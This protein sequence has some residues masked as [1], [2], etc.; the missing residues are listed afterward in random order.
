MAGLGGG[1]GLGAFII[2]SWLFLVLIIIFFDRIL[3]K[4]VKPLILSVIELFLSGLFFIAYCYYEREVIVDISDNK[5][6]YFIVFYSDEGLG[7]RSMDKKVLFDKKVSP[8]SNSILISKS[9]KEKYNIDFEFP[10]TW[11]R[12]TGIGSSLGTVENKID[13]EFFRIIPL[14]EIQKD[15]VL[16]LEINSAANNVYK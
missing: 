8:N 13:Y 9:V 2:L 1:A 12:G 11:G 3:V 4:K 5:A 7:E 10:S 15:S 16:K 6:G 14:T